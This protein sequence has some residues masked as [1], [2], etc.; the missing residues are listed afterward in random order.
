MPSAMEVETPSPEE[1]SQI[2]E[3]T[4]QCHH[5]THLSEVEYDIQKYFS[6]RYSIWSK[7]KQGIYMTDDSWFGVTPEPVANKV[8]EDFAALVPASKTILIDMFAGAGGNVIAFAL[9]GRWEKIIAIEKDISVIACAQH[10]ASIY[11]VASQITWIHSDCF[12]YLST[13]SSTIDPSKTV[14]FASP[15]WGGPRYEEGDVFNLSKMQPY[16][17][18]QIYGVVKSM[19]HALYLPRGSD[20]RQIARL[21]PEGKKIEVVQYCVFGASKAMV[22]YIPAITTEDTT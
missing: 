7:Y 16:S 1:G 11:G 20:L 22:A 8:A 6:Q 17:I 10:N 3:L 5:Y 13:Y 4:D 9:S 14:V 19:D 21:A 2:F 15:P 18:E 12:T